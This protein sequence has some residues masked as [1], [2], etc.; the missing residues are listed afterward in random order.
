[1]SSTTHDINDDWNLWAAEIIKL[2]KAQAV[3]TLADIGRDRERLQARA[4]LSP[5]PITG[6]QIIN[7]YDEET[8][9]FADGLDEAIIG[10]DE[11]SHRVIYSVT[12]ILAILERDLSPEEAREHYEF[13]ILGSFVG[14]QTPIWCDDEFDPLPDA[15]TENT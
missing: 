9:M 6:D 1:M 10:V 13:N 2:P 12:R 5:E 15:K 14:E 3:I 4:A 8:F 7:T 11:Q